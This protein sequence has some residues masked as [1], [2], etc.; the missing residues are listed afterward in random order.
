MGQLSDT[1]SENGPGK[2]FPKT[3]PLLEMMSQDLPISG[4]ESEN[5]R[6]FGKNGFP[7]RPA[8]G[9]F[10]R[11]GFL[12]QVYGGVKKSCFQSSWTQLKKISVDRKVLARPLLGG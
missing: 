12:K 11:K 4:H 9:K 6:V 7:N 2:R 10:L 5:G 8:F 1:I 3:G